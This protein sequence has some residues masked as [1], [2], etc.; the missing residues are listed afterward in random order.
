MIRRRL[1]LLLTL[2]FAWVLLS[3]ITEVQTLAKTLAG[4][5]WQ[6]IVVALLLQVVY[7]VAYAATYWASFATVGIASRMRDLLPL[8]FAAI[9]V[10][11]TAPSGGAAGV[12]LFV[13]DAGRRGHSQPRAAMG[14]L[15]QAATDFGAFCFILV[16]GLIVLVSRHTLRWYELAAAVAL[17][18]YVASMSGALLLGR[19]RPMWLRNALSWLQDVVNRLGARVR[20]PAFLAADWSERNAGEFIEA[21]HSIADRP[22]LLLRTVLIAWLAHCI[23]IIALEA[24]FLAFGQPVG[25]AVLIAGYATFV[26]F[27]IVSPTSNGV[28]IVEGIMPIIFVS[29][30]V[31]AAEAAVVTLSFRGISF[32]LP[33]LIG[34]VLMHRLPTFRSAE[35]KTTAARKM[36]FAALAVVVM[37]LIN[38]LS[39]A[40]PSLRDRVALL[41]GISPLEVR[42]GGHL[43]AALAGFALLL[44]ARGLWRYKRTAWLLTEVVLV[45]SVIAHLVK[46][47]D[48]E[49]AILAGSLAGY[50]WWQRSH[51][52]ALSDIPSLR[53]G[54]ITLMA[55]FLFTLGYGITGFYLLDRHFSVNFSLAAAVRQTTIMFTEFYDPGLVPITGFGRYFAASIYVVAAVT[56]GY[57]LWML[58]RPVLLR[59]PAGPEERRRAQIIVE[60][61]GRSSLARFT[62]APDKAYWFS[63][64][65]SV[66][67][68]AVR[69]HMAV[70]L[71]DPIGPANDA[72]ATIAGFRAF[73]SHNDWTSAFYQT[74][75]DY[76]DM[77]RA[78]GYVVLCIGHEGIVDLSTFTLSGGSNKNLRSTMNRFAKAGFRAVV[79]EPPL[80]DSLLA[81]LRPVSDEWLTSIH[82]NERRFSLGWF[83]DDYIRTSRVIAVYRSDGSISAFANFVSEYQRNEAAVDLMRHRK[84]AEPGTM[85][86]LMV[87]LLQWTKEHGFASFNLGLSALSGVGKAPGDP[88]AERALSYIYEHI[89]QF[90]N[91]K[92]LHGFKQKYHPNWEPR[93]LVF[94]G[95][96]SLPAVGFTLESAGSGPD[97]LITYAAQ[98]VQSLREAWLAD[99]PH[100]T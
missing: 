1:L 85:E 30:G 22:Q 29:L 10:N 41:A 65:G 58:L 95:Y 96:V 4:G 47:L 83:D 80:A 77:Y 42:A 37:G 18:L 50:L 59:R 92:G 90:Y 56:F 66:V 27:W 49:E 2:G 25:A 38:V 76:V 57:A 60:A 13:D 71:G 72:A 40:T 70:A 14:V 61:N 16:V 34:Y 3:R 9:F 73:C 79:H 31:P 55:A 48:Y 84:N 39:A 64:G 97:F 52:H 94:P 32:W 35:R 7:F 51:Y 20:R 88:A 8:T 74:L 100:L 5:R 33:L 91:F 28:G 67:A 82:G 24:V 68:Y 43:T 44:L 93:Y 26:L 54:L 86:F 98:T 23:N 6:W 15:L 45:L 46:G 53:Q 36:N 69:R 12:A 11:T 21:S 19:W 63:P 17:L 87:S 81:T 89:N 62:L 99:R 78:V 75:S